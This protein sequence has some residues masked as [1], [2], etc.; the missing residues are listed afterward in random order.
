MAYRAPLIRNLFEKDPNLP[1]FPDHTRRLLALL[2]NENTPLSDIVREV[3]KDPVLALRFVR[4]ANSPAYGF[5]RD[6]NT[7]ERALTVVGLGEISS[8]VASF[9]SVDSCERFLR[10][11]RFVWKDFW[12]HCSGTAFIAKTLAD[13]LSLNLGGAEFLS[14]LLHDIGYLALAKVDPALFSDA[15]TEAADHRGFLARG[16]GTRF[17]LSVETAGELLADVSHLAPETLDVIRHLHD[18]SHAPDERR[19][20]VSV[21]S[22]ANELAHLAGLTFFRGTAEV[23]V[24]VSELPA[25]KALSAGRPEMTRWDVAR[26]IFELEREHAASEAFVNVSHSN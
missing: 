6:V 21:V 5:R 10:D 16:L 3:E 7:L 20:L 15:V 23:E 14:G 1:S 22:L 13:R 25:W 19:T 8:V 2:R 24:V 11:P 9:A 17:G 4:L 12:A 18:P 26:L